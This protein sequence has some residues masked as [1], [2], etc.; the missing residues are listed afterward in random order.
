MNSEKTTDS[1]SDKKKPVGLEAEEKAP[2]Q[3]GAVIALGILTILF[4]A[5]TFY[6]GSPFGYKLLLPH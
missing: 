2:L 6:F 1:K 4:V 3:F 5:T